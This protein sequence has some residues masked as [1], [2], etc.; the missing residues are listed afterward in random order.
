MYTNLGQT[1]NAGNIFWMALDQFDPVNTA[2]VC[3]Y[4]PNEV[5]RTRNLNTD[6]P[7]WTLMFGPVLGPNGSN[8]RFTMVC[9]SSVQEGLWMVAGYEPSAPADI[10]IYWTLTGGDSW[11]STSFTSI[12]AESSY[13][14]LEMST[15]DANVAWAMWVDSNN[16]RTY[17]AKTDDMWASQTLTFIPLTCFSAGYERPCCH[18]RDYQNDDDSEV[19]YG[20][21]LF[22]AGPGMDYARVYKDG[23][24]STFYATDLGDLPHVLRVGCGAGTLNRWWALACDDNIETSFWISN[25]GINWSE[26]SSWTRSAVTESRDCRNVVGE[27]QSYVATRDG[28]GY[29]FVLSI[30][31]G[32]TWSILHLGDWA[33]FLADEG[34]GVPDVMC[35]CSS[36][37][38]P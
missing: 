16:A 3:A 8:I 14:F 28:I 15:H 24:C 34:L 7:D 25:D 12:D 23:V 18:H 30:D 31:R 33:I 35:L 37:L 4:N 2:M 22:D 19:L 9:S 26:Q 27:W 5:Y 21:C 6:A 11:N 36:N 1:P 20:G 13:T 10:F 29:P 32:E 17:I 38:L